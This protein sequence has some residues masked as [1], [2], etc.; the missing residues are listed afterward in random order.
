MQITTV[1]AIL[2]IHQQNC[3][4][5]G[6]SKKRRGRKGKDKSDKKHLKKKNNNNNKGNADRG[7]LQIITI[8]A[9]CQIWW[10]KK[11][12]KEKANRAEVSCQLLGTMI[13]IN[14][15]CQIHWKSQFYSA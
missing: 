15:I 14:P 2:Q 11:K 4:V 3:T 12:M 1:N 5:V 13:T 9:I 8:N 6:I 7:N 10:Q